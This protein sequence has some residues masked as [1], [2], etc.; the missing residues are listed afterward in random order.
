MIEG[1]ILDKF[2]ASGIG[3]VWVLFGTAVRIRS[4]YICIIAIAII[5]FQKK[6]WYTKTACQLHNDIRWVLA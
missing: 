5:T 3:L 1:L 4:S 2:L 6:I